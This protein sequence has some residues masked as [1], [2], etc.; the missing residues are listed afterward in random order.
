M[1]SSRRKGI[2]ERNVGVAVNKCARAVRSEP[3]YRVTVTEVHQSQRFLVQIR[4]LLGVLSLSNL[5]TLLHLLGFRL[6]LLADGDQ[7]VD[8]GFERTNEWLWI[9]CYPRNEKLCH[10]IKCWPTYALGLPWN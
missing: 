7:L 6:H 4:H 10:S 1:P 3:N 2:G 5:D 9:E 8:R